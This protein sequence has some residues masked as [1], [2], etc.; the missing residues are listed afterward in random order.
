M[1]EIHPG[2]IGDDLSEE[3]EGEG[4]EEERLRLSQAR[5]AARRQSE[6]VFMSRVQ[7][8]PSPRVRS[9]PPMMRT[10]LNQED[11]E[12]EEDQDQSLTKDL[13]SKLSLN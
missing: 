7:K 2:G 10:S 6:P 11:E 5:D 12:D 9:P 13:S 4:D 1:K 3:S 8:K